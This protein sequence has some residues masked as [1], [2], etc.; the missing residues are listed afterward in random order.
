MPFKSEAQRRWMYA[1]EARREVAKG[2]AKRW[3]RETRDKD[4]PERVSKKGKKKM[5][6]KAMFFAELDGVEDGMFTKRAADINVPPPQPMPTK[7]KVPRTPIVPPAP[8]KQ[9]GGDTPPEKIAMLGLPKTAIYSYGSGQTPS[10]AGANVGTGG[11]MMGTG[12]AP[13]LREDP[14]GRLLH[15]A[16]KVGK[17][18]Q[19]GVEKTLKYVENLSPEA[20]L[21]LAAGGGYVGAKKLLGI[22]KKLSRGAGAATSGTVGKVLRMARR[23]R[24]R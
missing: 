17:G 5:E 12:G 15:A 10:G 8:E 21:A 6:K 16:K 24:G 11:A 20:H 13:S 14:G 3:E 4:L 22:P 2:T 9:P 23:L 1:A 18:A 19:E 7:K